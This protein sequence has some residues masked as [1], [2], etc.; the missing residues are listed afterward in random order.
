MEKIQLQGVFFFSVVASCLVEALKNIL[1][2][3]TR[4]VKY[5]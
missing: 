3:A 2:V 1:C 5:L 4:K